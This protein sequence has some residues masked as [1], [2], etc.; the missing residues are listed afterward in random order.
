MAQKMLRN[1]GVRRLEG[2]RDERVWRIEETESGKK[3]MKKNGTRI[4]FRWCRRRTEK[5][6]HKSLEWNKRMKG[7]LLIKPKWL[8]S[9]RSG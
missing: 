1:P 2:G 7:S 8:G 3:E 4:N 6:T 5:C 9:E